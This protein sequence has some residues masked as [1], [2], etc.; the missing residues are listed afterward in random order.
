M[1]YDVIVIGAGVTGAAVARELSRY[2]GRIAVLERACD[3]AEGTSKA[4]SAIVHAGFDARPGSLKAKMNVAGNRMM[5]RLCEELAVPFQQNGAFVVCFEEEGKEALAG[6]LRQGEENG[7]TGLRLL[8]REEAAAMEPNLAES[9][10]YALYAPSSGIVCPFE[11]TLALAENA[12]MNGADFYF[13]TEVSDILPRDGGYRIVT[14]NGDFTC[15]AVVNAAGVY[16]DQIHN[17]VSG[18]AGGEKLTITARRG[19]Y[20][21]Y[22]KAAGNHVSHTIFQLPTAYGKGVLVTPTVHGNLLTGPTSVDTDDKEGFRTTQE[23]LRDV[24]RKS[25]LSVRDLPARLVITSFSGLRAHGDSGDFIIGETAPGF[26]EAAAIESPGLSSSPAI[27]ISVAQAAAGSLSLPKK[28]DFIERRKGRPHLAGMDLDARR[29][30]IEE[31]P[32]YGAI[33]CRCEEISEGEILD[34]IHGVIGAKTLDGIKRRTRAGMGRC[35]GGFCTPQ[36][37]KILARELHTDLTQIRKNKPDSWLVYRKT[38]EAQ[39]S[40]HAL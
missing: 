7:V 27:G 18:P 5:P 9:V 25:A 12:K 29:K 17:L 24:M 3:V 34:A 2:E 20:I 37:M 36:L 33:V 15:S 31:N 39:V 4:N 32:A 16:A 28:A 38:R 40:R 13:D 19:E 21:L 14:K 1:D 22:D 35:Q 30:L 23:G 10:R 26:F 6:L 11:L 8:N